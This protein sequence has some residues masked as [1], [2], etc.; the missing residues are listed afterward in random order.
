MFF[1]IHVL[2]TCVLCPQSVDDGSDPDA[3]FNRLR[4]SVQQDTEAAAAAAAALEEGAST[5]TAT[6]KV[7]PKKV[8]ALITNI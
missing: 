5:S 2:T 8:S 7:R 1:A 3:E 4:E 6:P